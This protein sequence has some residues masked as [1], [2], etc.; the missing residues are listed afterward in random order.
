MWTLSFSRT[1]DWPSI[2]SGL[3][4]ST[5]NAELSS[6]RLEP[7]NSGGVS[8]TNNSRRERCRVSMWNRPEEPSDAV[9]MSPRPSSTTNVSPYLSARGGRGDC[10]AVMVK[11]ASEA[12]SAE[13]AGA[14]ILAA[15]FTAVLGVIAVRL[16]TVTIG[17][18]NARFNRVGDGPIAF[19]HGV[20]KDGVFKEPDWA[21]HAMF[22]RRV[23]VNTLHKGTHDGPDRF[24]RMAARSPAPARRCRSSATI[25]PAECQTLVAPQNGLLS[26][27]FAGRT[28]INN[29]V[30]QRRLHCRRNRLNPHWRVTAKDRHI[31]V[32]HF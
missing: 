5:E 25:R 23:N 20:F 24:I 28:A 27:D 17:A 11:D 22:H 14:A 4:R 1:M 3:V 12:V 18:G 8:F 6:R 13:N 16:A 15:I 10:V 7:S 2:R 32:A 30:M 21:G 29:L 19:Q 26:F 9:P 31:E